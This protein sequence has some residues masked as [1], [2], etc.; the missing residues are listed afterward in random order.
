MKDDVTRRTCSRGDLLNLNQLD[1]CTAAR[2]RAVGL[3]GN[4]VRAAISYTGLR[5]TGSRRLP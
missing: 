5:S 4:E 2:G 1:D 3:S